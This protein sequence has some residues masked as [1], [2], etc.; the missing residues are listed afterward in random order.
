MRLK[1]HY[2]TFLEAC[3]DINL[4]IAEMIMGWAVG[5]IEG[6]QEPLLFSYGQSIGLIS[7]FCPTSVYP[8][9]LGMEQKLVQ[10]KLSNIYIKVLEARYLSGIQENIAGTFVMSSCYLRCLS[11]L[12][13]IRGWALQ[14]SFSEVSLRPM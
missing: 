14:P 11:A 2:Y 12:D 4:D 5:N 9:C 7:D 6:T 8:D 1:T 3:F 10:L 13:V